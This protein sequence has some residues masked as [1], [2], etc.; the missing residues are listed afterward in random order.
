M[1]NSTNSV[2]VVGIGASS[3]DLTDAAR[4]VLPHAEVVIGSPRQLEVVADLTPHAEKKRLPRSVRSGLPEMLAEVDGLSTV[5]LASGDPMFHGIGETLVELLGSSAVR[6]I[7]AV[8]CVTLACARLGWSTT[9]VDVVSLVTGEVSLLQTHLRDGARII[10]M[11]RDAKSPL[12][13]AKYLSK[14]PFGGSTAL[15]LSDLGAASESLVPLTTV[16][17][18]GIRWTDL[19][20]VAL[21]VNGPR[22]ASTVPGLPDSAYEHDGQITKREV[23]SVVM[24]YLQ[25]ADGELLWDLGAGAGSISIEWLRAAPTAQAICVERNVNR[26]LTLERNAETHGVSRLRAVCGDSAKVIPDLPTPDA[27]FIG[28]GARNNGVVSEAWKALKPGGRL[29]ATAVTLETMG[30]LTQW[31]ELAGGDLIQIH[32]ARAD[33]VG[34]MR[35]W[36]PMRPVMIWAATKSEA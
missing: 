11:S 33:E 5:V 23:R 27:V 16:S 26:H 9:D 19:N 29:V 17:E 2:T 10:V 3:E 30:L 12:E 1:E 31:A 25:P 7:P 34:E 32:V 28:G 35:S 4:A 18:D 21:E 20:V 22:A 6:I 15:V 14:G 24:G 36:D 13:V 8:S